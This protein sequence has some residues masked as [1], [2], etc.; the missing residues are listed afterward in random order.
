MP[1][2]S[3]TNDPMAPSMHEEGLAAN[4]P[5]AADAVLGDHE[6]DAGVVL[7]HGHGIQEL[8]GVA[9]AAGHDRASQPGGSRAGFRKEAVVVSL[10]PAQPAA[11]AVEGEARRRDDDGA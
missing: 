11:P 3:A 4:L 2:R 5:A 10:A 1:D 8:E 6:I 9:E 7:A